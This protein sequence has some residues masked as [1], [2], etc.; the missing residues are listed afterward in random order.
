MPLCDLCGKSTQLYRVEIE[1]A[2]LKVCENCAKYGTLLEKPSE[3][4]PEREDLPIPLPPTIAA[5]SMQSPIDDNYAQVV[6]SAREKAKLT[7]EE[8]AKAI[9]EKENIIHRIEA[10][11]Q[12]PSTKIA[13]KLEQFLHIKLINKGATQALAPV[14]RDIDFS[15]ASMTIG[16]LLK[17]QKEVKGPSN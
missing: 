5:E 17:M 9:A 7:Q 16:D 2:K 11:Q 12:E 3:R 6:K 8:L 13:K 10:R 14:L 15:E 1:N 4:A